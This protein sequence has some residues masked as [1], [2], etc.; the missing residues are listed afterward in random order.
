MSEAQLT[1][2]ILAWVVGLLLSLA[3]KVIARIW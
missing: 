3:S 1:V 2:M